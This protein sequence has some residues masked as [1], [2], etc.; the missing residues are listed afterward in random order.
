ME[1]NRIQH[2]FAYQTVYRILTVL[3]PLITSP[4]LSRALGA[5]KLGV[6]S[7]TLAFVS[8]FQLFSLLGVE[9]YGSRSIAAAQGDKKRLESLFWNIYAIQVIASLIAIAIYVLICCFLPVERR[10]I[11]RLQ[12]LWLIGALLNINWFFFGTEQFRLTVTRNII[13]KIISLLLIVLFVKK[14]DDIFVYVLIMAGDAVVTNAV[15]WPFLIRDISFKRPSLHLMREHISPICVLFVPILAMSVFHIMDKSML[16]WLSTETYVG[17]YYTADKV[18]SIPLSIIT[19]LNTVMLPRVSNEFSKGNK[20]HVRSMLKNSTEATVFL[21]CAIGFGISSVAGIFVPWFFGKEYEPCI[22]LV[23]V[24]V[25]VFIIK[26]I[27]SM[28][29][30]QYMIPSQM[31]KQFTISVC[32]GAITNLFANYLLIQKYQALGAV[33]GTLLAEFVVA[34]MQLLYA[35]KSIPFTQFIAK[36][37]PY[38]MFG[39]IMSFVVKT[40]ERAV[41]APAMLKLLC[42][43]AG[44]ALVYMVLCVSYWLMSRN[45]YFGKNKWIKQ[46]KAIIHL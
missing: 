42:M 6:F 20:Q 38:F 30:S 22:K 27:G 23:Y 2:N 40:I 4:I 44:G 13:I 10:M 45:S 12:G 29:R 3:T 35:R 46:L 17:Y 34:V 11:S 19:G 31:D 8:Y 41:S 33:Y 24:F 7:A 32:C 16:D 15:L 26:S 21:A 5:E 28:V 43:I 25:P 37:W 1:S 14:P 39:V 18:I 9:N 36:Q